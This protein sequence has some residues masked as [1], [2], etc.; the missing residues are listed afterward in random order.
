MSDRL[1]QATSLALVAEE[2]YDEVPDH[3]PRRQ[4]SSR[5]YVA[6]RRPDRLAADASGDAEN[7]SFHYDGKTLS[8]FDREQNVW[9]SGTVPR[10]IDGMLDYVYDQTDT[11]IPLADFLY[12]SAFERLM[13]SI[14][15]GTYLGIHQ[16][17]GVACHH[18][19]FEQANI[20]WQIWIDAGKD[21]V[22]RKLVITYKTEDEV[23]QYT[24]TILKWNLRAALPDALF[25]FEP[26]ADA[27]RIDIPAVVRTGGTPAAGGTTR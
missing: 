24:V 22:P 17:A 14:Q 8:V 1:A 25:V 16:A 19:A 15:R 13:D 6:L 3:E 7:Q 21:P 9:V 27:T 26:P 5:R 11:V 12:A 4:V 18:L 23:P 10:T 2:T 20:D